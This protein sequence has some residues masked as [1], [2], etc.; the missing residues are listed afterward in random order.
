MAEQINIF[1]DNKP[2]RLRAVTGILADNGIN[3]RAV[4]IQDH[5][6]YGMVKMLVD[7]PCRA[8]EFL[9]T[10]GFACALKNVLT[11]LV[12][13]RPGGLHRLFVAL[14]EKGINVLDAYGFI[15]ES[16]KE[17]AVCIEV[18]S[19]DAA[20]AIAEKNGFKLISA[21]EIYGL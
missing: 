5:T 15:V 14:D 2:G 7:E 20:A 8:R 21:E 19:L 16:R 9:T 1:L 17:A 4:V 18:Q 13:D 11:V 6:D 10:A 12:P 3:L